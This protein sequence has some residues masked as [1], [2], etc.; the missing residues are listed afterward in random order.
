MFGKQIVYY[1]KLHP[2][3]HIPLHPVIVS[4]IDWLIDSVVVQGGAGV[5][6]ELL[7]GDQPRGEDRL[8]RVRGDVLR[9]SQIYRSVRSTNLK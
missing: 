8:R 2:N 4:M 5:P 3:I 9:T 7:P 6:A 1:A